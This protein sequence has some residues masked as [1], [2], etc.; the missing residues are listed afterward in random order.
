MDSFSFTYFTFSPYPSLLPHLF[1]KAARMA[2]SGFWSKG[3]LSLLAHS[4]AFLFSPF[5]YNFLP[6][7]LRWLCIIHLQFFFPSTFLHGS[8]GTKSGNREWK[9]SSLTIYV[10]SGAFARISTTKLFWHSSFEFLQKDHSGTSKVISEH[11]SHTIW[12]ERDRGERE[13]GGKEE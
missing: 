12:T 2:Y 10:R 8:L 11:C 4:S 1:Y 6:N 13:N 7:L 5:L 3:I 9:T